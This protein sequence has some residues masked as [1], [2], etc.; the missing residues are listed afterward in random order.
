MS[1]Y[2]DRRLKKELRNS[3]FAFWFYWEKLKLRRMR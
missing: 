2:H 3:W 1:D